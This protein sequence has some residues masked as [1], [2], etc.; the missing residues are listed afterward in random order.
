MYTVLCY[1]GNVFKLFESLSSLNCGYPWTLAIISLPLN[2]S[3]MFLAHSSDIA[4]LADIVALPICGITTQLFN[5]S[6]GWSVGN[7]SGVVTSSPA[8]RISSET[9]ASYKSSW[10]TRPPRLELIKMAVFFIF[11]KAAAFIM[12]AVSSVSLQLPIR[13]SDSLRSF[14]KETKS[15]GSSL[16]SVFPSRPL[17]IIRL[18]P[19][20]LRRWATANPI[21]PSPEI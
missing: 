5:F 16:A 14:S 21:L 4:F 9:R 2:A 3:I 8:A 20:G 13:K 12:P 11:L 17:Y 15:A 7:G 19:N 1:V 10:F 6:N 18:T